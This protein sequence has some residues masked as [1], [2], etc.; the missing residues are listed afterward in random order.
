MPARLT[1]MAEERLATG[2]QDGHRVQATALKVQRLKRVQDSHPRSHHEDLEAR[3]RSRV[4]VNSYS[5]AASD[6]YDF[7]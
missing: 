5:F 6:P 2:V 3:I 4:Y 7:K 1:R